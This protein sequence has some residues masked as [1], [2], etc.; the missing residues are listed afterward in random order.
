MYGG[1]V[2]RKSSSGKNKVRVPRS[3][4]RGVLVIDNAPLR[5]DSIR[6]AEKWLKK[7]E[8]VEH[9][10]KNFQ[11][12]DLKLYSDWSNLTLAPLIAKLEE[13]R[14]EFLKVAAF[15]NV[16]VMLAIDMR[17]TVPAAYNFLMDEEHQYEIGNAKT[18][19]KIEQRRVERMKQLEDEMGYDFEQAHSK[20]QQ[21]D[22]DHPKKGS[23]NQSYTKSEKKKSE[24]EA[25]FESEQFD[26]HF[27]SDHNHQ[28]KKQKPHL[29]EDDKLKVKS[30]FR[31]IVR[32]IHPD[33][34]NLDE[35]SGLKIWFQIIWKT[36]ADAHEDNDLKKLQQL[37]QKTV[38]ALK[39]YDELS[40]S[41]LKNAAESLETEYDLLLDHYST[42]K[43]SPAWN[44]SKLK[45]YDQLEK[46]QAKPYRQ[47]QRLIDEEIELIKDQR[48]EIER[49]AR[50]LREGKIE[51]RRPR[52]QS[53]GRSRAS[54][55]GRGRARRPKS[56]RY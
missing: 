9:S 23:E 55:G 56:Q 53:G 11:E 10:A 30:L 34:L 28:A 15:H 12:I 35:N 2:S 19:A 45:N 1:G 38:L 20:S 22:D 21:Q 33:H 4:E 36:V 7:I 49:I 17:T 25:D 31:K 46:Q 29:S 39:D 32:R 18:R 48:T 52:R 6:L 5:V 3:L 40:I 16:L 54:S 47:Q 37:Y 8:T 43:H 24:D 50:L 14:Q 51:L 26:E 41:E 42:F 44:F 13:S 27:Y